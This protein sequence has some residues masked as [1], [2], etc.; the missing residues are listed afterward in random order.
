[1]FFFTVFITGNYGFVDYTMRAIFRSS[2]FD[3]CDGCRSR[4][5][6]N[7]VENTLIKLL[8]DEDLL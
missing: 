3:R 2:N 4:L 6:V 1:M 5:D 7:Y 8:D